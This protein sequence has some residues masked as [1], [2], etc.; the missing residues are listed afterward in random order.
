[1]AGLEV[2]QSVQSSS[3]LPVM[4]GTEKDVRKDLFLA[5]SNQ[6]RA[7]VKDSYKYI[8]YNVEGVF[9]EQLFNLQDDPGEIRNLASEMPEKAAEMKALLVGR[10][11]EA[12]D[13][14][15]ADNP[16]WWQDGHKMTWK[17][18]TEMFIYE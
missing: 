1:M 15:D 11:K 12:G 8:M 17:E 7:L 6:Q 4:D 5:Y 13:F 9:T 3:L 10:M 2:P 14:C 18:I 16:L